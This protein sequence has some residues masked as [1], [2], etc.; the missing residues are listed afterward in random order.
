MQ[1]MGREV[2]L[3]L[4]SLREHIHI[5]S[6]SN[7][8]YTSSSLKSDSRAIENT[9]STD[10]RS[11]PILGKE[12]KTSDKFKLLGKHKL[13]AQCGIFLLAGIKQTFVNKVEKSTG[14]TTYS[15]KDA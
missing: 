3:I 8:E 7:L 11:F 12:K 15:S 13:G 5:L 4:S 1:E 14:K 6:A 10:L 9:L 2:A